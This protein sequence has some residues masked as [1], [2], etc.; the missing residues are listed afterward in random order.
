MSEL[1]SDGESL[2]VESTQ[3]VQAEANPILESELA[4]ESETTASTE[5]AEQTEDSNVNQ[6]KVQKVINKKHFEK[7]EAVRRAEA[8]EAKLKEIEDK[9]LEQLQANMGVIPEMPDPYEDDYESKVKARDEAIRKNAEFQAQQQVVQQNQQQAEIAR[10]QREQAEL[11]EKLNTYQ[12]RAKELGIN[13]QELQHAANTVSSYGLNEGAAMAILN[14]SDG[15]LI[16]KY[17][18]SN[19]VEIERLNN[20]SQFELG[21]LWS[22]VKSKAV[23]LKPKSSSA[24]M[25]PTNIDGGGADP[26]G[27]KYDVIKGYT[28]E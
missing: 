10:Q 20:V 15:A 27:G 26:D 16:T 23:A 7:M 13:G 2:P 5:N 12:K 4:T 19:P 25:P 1:Q 18:A 17:L 22:D 6:D 9:K 24:P 14:D 28:L 3:E 21:M 11:N 8:A